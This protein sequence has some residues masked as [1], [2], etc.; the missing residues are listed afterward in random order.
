MDAIG[1]S[2]TLTGSDKRAY[3]N[4]L[5]G[6]VGGWEAVAQTLISSFGIKRRPNADAASE[7][8][9]VF[10]K[11]FPVLQA[12]LHYVAYFLAA[13]VWNDDALG[14][15]RF[16]DLLLRWLQPFYANLQAAYLFSSTLILTPDLVTQEWTNVEAEVARRMRFH[17]EAAAPG[18]ASGILLW[19]V[20]CD[21]ICISGLVALYWYATNQQPSE[22]AAQA[23][24]LTL[25]QQKR[26]SDGSD[27]TVTTP[28]TTFRLLFDFAI[29]YALNPRFVQGR[30]SAAIDE[31]VS[32]LT[33]LATPRMVSGRVYGG[34]G[35][36]GFETLR[37]VLLAVMV[38]NLPA[39][40]DDGVAT[41]VEDLKNDPMFQDDA[42]VRNFIWTMQQMVQAVSGAQEDEVFKKA[43]QTFSKG[44]DLTTATDG[45][46]QILTS[47]VFAFETLRKERLR[48]A[49]LDDELMEIV[50]H[51]ITEGVL[52]RG[53][54]IA[55]FGG[56]HIG[57]DPSG[58]IAAAETE[59]GVVS[60]GSFVRPDMAGVDFNELPKMFVQVSRDYLAN[61]V[62]QG[63][64]H[65]PKRIVTIDL[66]EGTSAFWH[67]VIVEAPEV[68]PEPIVLVPFS[69][70]G[71]EI[72]SAA[73]RLMSHGLPYFEII[74]AAN[75]PSGGGTAYLGTIEGIHV[76]STHMMETSAILCSRRLL[77]EIS[78]GIVRGA[79]DIV[80]FW[81]VES[82]N[83]E[84][85][86][87]RLKFAQLIHWADYV[88]VEFDLAGTEQR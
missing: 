16:R 19:E 84:A 69:V 9:S 52:A 87:V 71:E 54:D 86:Q 64:F 61:L 36:D 5:I 51:R 50:R 73:H 55:C 80:D 11:S 4:V 79:N 53:P 82:E 40:G 63:L 21:V 39:R 65:R 85:S 29:R 23:A 28:K 44:L 74:R 58:T 72:S 30:Y 57:R 34:F 67:R 43:A 10:G 6:F 13:A 7:Q 18:P 88:F 76:Y 56:Y 12:H 20:Y 78:Y 17:Q 8:W 42:A 75:V 22:T 45:L 37:P 49:P 25:R 68:G 46:R 77:R 66:S 14:A 31:L 24:I 59:F 3:E 15:D 70:L 47:V 26:T 81:L 48:A 38:A 27:L 1:S 60:K 35:I 32:F 83:P 33:N 2:T 41:V 62:W